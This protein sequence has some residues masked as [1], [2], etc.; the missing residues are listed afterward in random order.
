MSEQE[1]RRRQAYK[2]RRKRWIAAQSVIIVLVAI[3]IAMS[4]FTYHRLNQEYYVSYN[5]S[6]T[7]DYKVHLADNDFYD[8]EW[9]GKDHSYV[10]SLIDKINAT[11][12]YKLNMDAANVDYEYSYGI[13][14]E[15]VITDKQSS[16]PLYNPTTVIKPETVAKQNSGK[17][18]SITESFEIDYPEFNKVANEFVSKYDLRDVSCT[19]LVTMK[20]AVK[21]SSAAFESDTT[22]NY[23]VSLSVPL[24]SRTV[25]VEITSTIPTSEGRVLAYVGDAD[26]ATFRNTTII[27]SLVDIILIIILIAF[28]YLNYYSYSI[29]LSYKKRRY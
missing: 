9:V 13:V 27:S 29:Y 3:I 10:A 17:N 23:N 19:L 18:L 11:F 22:N 8:D 21:G 25:D 24:T 14:A 16:L 15:L 12:N 2:L 6:S 4:A 20:V 28:I 1:R 7:V 5:E 26:R